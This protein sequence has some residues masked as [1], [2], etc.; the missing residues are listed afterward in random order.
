MSMRYTIT[1]PDNWGESL[2]KIS[3]INNLQEQDLMRKALEYTYNL[4]CPDLENFSKGGPQRVSQKMITGLMFKTHECYVNAHLLIDKILPN[5]KRGYDFEKD[6]W[7]IEKSITIREHI[8]NLFFEEVKSP[9]GSH[10]NTY[11]RFRSKFTNKILHAIKA[12]NEHIIILCPENSKIEWWNEEFTPITLTI[13][14]F[15][16]LFEVNND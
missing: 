3:S 9:E 14:E 8:Y 4:N 13:N 6:L 15:C 2:K 11:R 12:S 1:V 10:L 7:L 5:N 16:N